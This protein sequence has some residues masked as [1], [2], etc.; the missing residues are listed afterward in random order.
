VCDG[1]LVLVATSELELGVWN[2]Y[3][4]R[5]RWTSPGTLSDFTSEGSGT[6]DLN[7]SGDLVAAR[8]L[9]HNI[10]IFESYAIGVLTQAG[11][12]YAPWSYR[13]ISEGVQL[14]SNP[15]V[16]DDKVYFVDQNGL[17]EYTN[18]IEVVRATSPFDLSQYVDL[19]DELPVWL[20][21]RKS[22]N[23]LLVYKVD[24]AADEA[25]IFVI[26]VDGG[27][28]TSLDVPIFPASSDSSGNYP[29]SLVQVVA[30]YATFPQAPVTDLNKEAMVIVTG[31]GIAGNG[32]TAG[33]MMVTCGDLY[34]RWTSNGVNWHTV[35]QTK[36][37]IAVAYSSGLSQWC[38]VGYDGAIL[39]SSNGKTWTDRSLAASDVTF[40]GLT[41]GD[42]E[43][44][45]VG[46]AS[47]TD[48][49]PVV[50]SSTNGTS[51][52]DESPTGI[53]DTDFN[54]IAWDGSTNYA[55][56][57]TNTSGSGNLTMYYT[58]D[59]DTY[60]AVDTGADHIY[61]ARAI[62][63]GSTTFMAVGEYCILD[64]SDGTSW[65]VLP[66]TDG[67]IPDPPNII[68]NE[69]EG[70]VWNGTTFIVAGGRLDCFH[71]ADAQAASLDEIYQEFDVY[72][73][74]YIEDVWWY[75]SKIYCATGSDVGIY[76]PH[77][78]FQSRATDE[79]AWAD[80]GDSV[81]TI[82]VT[83]SA[84]TGIG[85]AW[86]TTISRG[87]GSTVAFTLPCLA[88]QAR[89]YIGTT[90]QVLNTDYTITDV[91]EITL[92]TAPDG[93]SFVIAYWENEPHVRM[94]AG[95]Y[96]ETSEGLHRVVAIEDATALKLAWYPSETLV[97]THR[98]AK[99]VPEQEG[100]TVVGLAHQLDSLQSKIL[101][102]PYPHPISGWGLTTAQLGVG[103]NAD[104]CVLGYGASPTASLLLT[105][106]IGLEHA[107]TGVDS[108]ANL[109]TYRERWWGEIQTGEVVV[110]SEGQKTSVK[111]VWIR[112]YCGE[113]AEPPIELVGFSVIHV[114]AGPRV[115]KA[116][117]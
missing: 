40:L 90:A 49:T 108:F 46:R 78:A 87:D 31:V 75:D 20:V 63:W 68:N 58:P 67:G 60:T 112:T 15:V 115:L 29:H 89:I 95:D 92:A 106:R 107:A 23:C 69:L 10:I 42:S 74:A 52:T 22:V 57:T 28:T 81:G 98:P 3:P 99:Q 26:H 48:H 51:W 19:G 16:I 76:T 34:T 77:V 38:A 97:G 88:T 55:I 93:D 113:A 111:E 7:G 83:T 41:W 2:Y 117:R 80:A 116:S 11:D 61:N 33:S 71:T 21:Y 37:L 25:R 66:Y 96:I 73:A 39:T 9:G 35:V 5:V 50:Y 54:C 32:T 56:G 14:A 100:E 45:A 70:V 4:R 110:L 27:T 85:T 84:C 103:A 62:T 94:R 30:G 109:S 59:L 24:S 13:R 114:P 44:A 79:D 53:S 91:K 8:N 6:A 72:S 12:I 82:S 47:D 64:S 65:T 86:S 43:W 36:K 17:L 1:Y 105:V 104:F 18:G 101:V 102:I